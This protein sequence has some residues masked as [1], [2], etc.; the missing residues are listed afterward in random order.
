MLVNHADVKRRRVV[1]VADLYLNAILFNN[2][3]LGLVQAEQDTHQCRLACTVLAKQ[4]MDFAAP[5]LKGDV[6]IRNDAGETLRYIQHLNDV[7]IFRFRSG[8][9]NFV[10]AHSIHSFTFG[11]CMLPYLL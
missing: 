8:L 6:V 11:M 9:C 1:R 3:F 7:I 4:G 10:H 2:A 5:E